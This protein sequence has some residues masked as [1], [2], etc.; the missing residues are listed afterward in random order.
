MSYSV[1]EV[2]RVA[3]VSVRTLH[4]YDEIGLL[5]PSGRTAA[6]YREYAGSDLGR[7][8]RILCYRELGF[9]LRTIGAMLDD[10][11]RDPLDH[12][13]RQR[14]LLQGK[15]R[16]LREMVKS[17]DKMMEAVQMGVNLT[18]QEMFEVFGEFDPTEHA[19]EVKERWGDTEAYRESQRRTSRYS[20]E[21]WERLG[22]ESEAITQA[23]GSAYESG[24]SAESELAMDLAEQAR[25]HIDRWFYACSPE[26][27]RNLG[28]MYVNDAR[29]AKVYDDRAAGLSVF[30]RDAIR[31]NAARA[32]S[33]EGR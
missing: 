16:Q 13:R 1:G 10:P 21:D 18:P 11:E 9:D 24:V 29:F 6:G 22:R 19:E 32:A 26:M 25:Q 2:A 20:K 15:I 8:Q 4:H 30:V 14:A 5:S 27:H 3:G 7:L 31:A 23:L 17:A 33:S 28:E 12:L